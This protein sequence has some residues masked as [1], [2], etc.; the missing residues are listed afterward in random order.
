[1][2]YKINSRKLVGL[3]HSLNIKTSFE[4]YILNCV[5]TSGNEVKRERAK[6]EKGNYLCRVRK[7]KTPYG[8]SYLL[9]QKYSH[10][11]RK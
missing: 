3:L 9:F 6:L 1:M 2:I 5:C 4:G 10:K 8:T 11:R 7:R